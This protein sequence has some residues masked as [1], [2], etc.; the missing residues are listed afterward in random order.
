M[1]RGAQNMLHILRLPTLA[2]KLSFLFYFSVFAWQCNLLSNIAIKLICHVL[3][4][5]WQGGLCKSKPAICSFCQM[6]WTN[7]FFLPHGGDGLQK[8]TFAGLLVFLP[9]GRGR[10]WQS[11]LVICKRAPLARHSERV[12]HFSLMFS[13]KREFCHGRYQLVGCVVWDANLDDR[14]RRLSLPCPKKKKHR[15]RVFTNCLAQ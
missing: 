12:R 1:V 4:F 13:H 14:F 7:S 10:L 2:L 6:T 11:G 15:C 3:S 8:S 5:M 9:H